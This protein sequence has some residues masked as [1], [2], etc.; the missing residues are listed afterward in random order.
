MNQRDDA[1]STEQ[2][3][4]SGERGHGAYGWQ[5]QYRAGPYRQHFYGQPQYR[6]DTYRGVSDERLRQDISKRLMEAQHLDSSA[7]RV[8]VQGAKVIIEGAVADRRVKHAIEDLV[9]ACPGV[10][11]IDNRVK[12]TGPPG[13]GANGPR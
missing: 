5:D 4:E 7:V 8:S 2:R 3:R 9:D 1:P 10:Q 12:V 11:D 13:R 6:Q